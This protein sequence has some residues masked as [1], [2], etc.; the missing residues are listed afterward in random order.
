MGDILK[1]T[2]EHTSY[3]NDTL[4]SKLRLHINTCIDILQM[5]LLV[6]VC[7]LFERPLNVPDNRTLAVEAIGGCAAHHLDLVQ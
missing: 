6:G 5:F 2:I 7:E 4:F 1:I 3:L